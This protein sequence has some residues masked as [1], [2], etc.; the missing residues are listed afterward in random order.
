[1]QPVL[2]VLTP[3]N[4]VTT[5]WSGGTT[6]Q[7]SIAPSDALYAE[8]DFLWRISSA[9]VDL[10]ESDFTALPDYQ[11]YI[12]TLRGDMTLTHDGGA[13]LTLRPGDVHAFDGGVSTHS[14]G[15]CTDFNLMLRKERTDGTMDALRLRASE[16]RVFKCDARAE[17]ALLYCA[18]GV[19]TVT[20]GGTVLTLPSGSSALVRGAAGAELTLDCEAPAFLAAAQMW[21]L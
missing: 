19:C 7:L 13:P 14:A 3:E 1:M 18:E 4:Y 6:T 11:R 12:S 15:R 9:T 10:D 2:T 16:R 21:L 17:T 5:S 8:R 20:L